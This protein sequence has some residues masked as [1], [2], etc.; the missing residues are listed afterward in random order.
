MDRTWQASLEVTNLTNK[1]YYLTQFDLAEGGLPGYTAA[2]P[3]TG[4]LWAL[5]VKKTF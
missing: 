5:T 1:I 4:R 2:Q 3:A